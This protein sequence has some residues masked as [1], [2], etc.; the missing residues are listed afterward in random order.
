MIICLIPKCL[1][2]APSKEQYFRHLR[3]YHDS[4]SGYTCVFFGCDRKYSSLKTYREHINRIHN[5]SIDR[6]RENQLNEAIRPSTSNSVQIPRVSKQQLIELTQAE[7]KKLETQQAIINRELIDN[8]SKSCINLMLKWLSKDALPRKTAFEMRSEI[9]TSVIEPLINIIDDMFL[10]GM[11]TIEC[12]STIIQLLK[13]FDV[14]TEYR[15]LKKLEKE[16]LYSPPILFTIS[17]ELRPGV[18]ESQQ[19]MVSSIANY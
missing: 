16:G 7:N 9:L 13:T 15:F 19:Q 14:G 17:E 5:D 10:V 12:K 4:L 8:M 6:C 18:I 1:W 2:Q 3:R 11:M